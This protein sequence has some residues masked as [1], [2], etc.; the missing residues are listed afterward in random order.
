MIQQNK[1]TYYLGF[2]AFIY[3]VF[4]IIGIFNN[5]S[6]VPFWDMW[7][8]YL[9]F[10]TKAQSGDWYAWIAQHNEHRVF[11]SR[12]LFWVDI[13]FFDGASY[14]LLV[15]NFLL[16]IAIAYTFYSFIRR[17]LDRESKI[18]TWLVLSV[19][20]LSF[21]WIQKGNITWGFQ[22]QFFLAY[23]VPLV[24]FYLLALN[25]H[26]SQNKY[27]FL[28]VV[29]G[30]L[31]VFTMGNGIVTLPLL[32]VL[33]FVLKLSKSKQVMLILVTVTTLY[34]YFLDYV[35]PGGH[36][37]LRETLMQHP[38]D[39]FL[40]ILTY[41]GGPFSKVF[42]SSKLF[43]TQF[44]GLVFIVG[45]LFFA[46]L[47]FKKRENVFV[48]ALLTFI[49]YIGATAFGTSGGRAIFGLHQ[50]LESRYM[51]PSLMGWSAFLILFVYFYH[52]N[53]KVSKS[54][55]AIFILLPLMFLYQQSKALKYNTD[56]HRMIATLALELNIEDEEMTN[57]IF[58]SY[59]WLSALAKEPA[60]LNLSIFGNEL[61]KDK[62]LTFNA[63]IEIP[64]SDF[65]GSLDEVQTLKN[66]DKFFRVR[67]WIFD[68]EHSRVPSNGY[69]VNEASEVVGYILS[70]FERPDVSD[71]IGREARYSGYYGYITRDYSGDKFFIVND[72]FKQKLSITISKPLFEI[73]NVVDSDQGALITVS[74]ILENSFEKNK[75]HD[76]KPIE[77]LEVFGSFI[78][79][80]LSKAHV[81]IQLPKNQENK[82]RYITGPQVN[83]QII[84]LYEDKRLIYKS[85][86]KISQEWSVINFGLSEQDRYIE[87]IDSSSDWGEWT[88]I[89]LRSR[90]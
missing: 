44:F 52:H 24:S 34:L 90:E 65:I 76:F 80:D 17:L 49:A 1:L 3:V 69:I 10:Y 42:G 20:I 78:A 16:M 19:I 4:V 86:L 73:E 88:A 72:V 23:L 28:A 75:M 77:D 45:S 51:T 58:P 87:I 83:G 68:N 8:G 39:F 66:E 50:A 6:P 13:H 21:S 81:K 70:G 29:G 22:S 84:C 47:E 67:G 11:L 15:C 14:F 48:F 37:S 59:S 53:L 82:I 31:S 25:A 38:K 35:A 36:G 40:Y 9:E 54:I 26:T 32:I 18:F 60:K 2:F 43:I 7:D 33:G 64:K 89:A 5:Y 79:G 71:A 57:H 12:I 56:A 61:I 46:F 30:V 74:S 85:N 41:L 62:A 27:F 63:K 55:K